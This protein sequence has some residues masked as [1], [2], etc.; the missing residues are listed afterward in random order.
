MSRGAPVLTFGFEIEALLDPSKCNIKTGYDFE[1]MPLHE[2]I[3]NNFADQRDIVVPNEAMEIIF[4]LKDMF[5]GRAVTD[6]TIL[7]ETLGHFPFEF[8]SAPED[9]TTDLL[10]RLKN[11]LIHLTNHG[12]YAND[13]CGFHFHFSYE[14]ISKFDLMWIKLFYLFDQRSEK[15]N[16]FMSSAGE[17]GLWSDQYA[18]QGNIKARRADFHH[19][20]DGMGRYNDPEYHKQFNDFFGQP[21]F[22]SK[23]TVFGIHDKYR[24]LEWRGPRGFM[25]GVV[26]ITQFID[27]LRD[28]AEWL[29]FATYQGS[30]MVGHTKVRREQFRKLFHN[31]AQEQYRVFGVDVADAV[32]AAE[33]NEEK[34]EAMIGYF[35]HLDLLSRHSTNSRKIANRIKGRHPEAWA[36]MESRLI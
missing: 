11:T 9:L 19:I 3:T 22:S 36:L 26:D 29:S 10:E 7:P 2:I 32:D 17:I 12:V 16:S 8:T 5:G 13:S 23:Y 34:V 25:G 18:N 31:I 6:S 35:R 15:F 14:G 24:T 27:L 21:Y 1:R 33:T 4:Y 20:V 28:F 30:I